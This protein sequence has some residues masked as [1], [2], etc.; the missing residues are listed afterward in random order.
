M[1]RAHELAKE[2]VGQVGDY[3]VALSIT[4]KQAWREFKEGVEKVMEYAK[5]VSSKVKYDI[6]DNELMLVGSNRQPIWV[7]VVSGLHDRFGLDRQFVDCDKV[8]GRVDAW[9]LKEGVLYNYQDQR[10]QYFVRL[11][12][13]VLNEYTKS[14]VE[15]FYA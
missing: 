9:E 15:A 3:M 1:V 7:A 10:E 2:I 14:Q 13:G 5:N 12:N 6:K 4:L 8:D 11:E